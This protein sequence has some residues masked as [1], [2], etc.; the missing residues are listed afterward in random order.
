MLTPTYLTHPPS[1]RRRFRIVLI[2]AAVFFLTCSIGGAIYVS[3]YYRADETAQQALLSSKQVTVL[4]ADE[5]IIFAPASADPDAGFI[6]YPGGKV[7]HT[8]YAPLLHTLAQNGI[9]CVL[10]EMPLR[11]A[12]L[13]MNAADGIP[14]EM[15]LQYPSIQKWYIG[16]HS[17]GGSMAASHAGGT[18]ASPYS[19]LV[20]LA[21]YSTADLAASGM[22]VL[23]LYGTC[24]QVL[25]AEKYQEY[26]DNLPAGT[27]EIVLKGANHAQFGSYGSQ[28]GDGIAEI[29]ASEQLRLTL[30]YLLDF[31]EG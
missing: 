25:N 11:L 20:L 31:F 26:F 17:L 7:E 29:S 14:E 1:R 3:D 9:L 27:T 24:D 30:E 21:S 13:D 23:S 8:A 16:G 28:K 6:F 2:L 22:N 15:Q 18:T 10:C 19:G 4:P 12:V 5:K